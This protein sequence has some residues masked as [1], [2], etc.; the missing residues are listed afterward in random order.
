MPLFNL[1]KTAGAPTQPKSTT[2]TQQQAKAGLLVTAELD[3]ALEDC[4]ARV[5]DIAK[6]CR[7]KNRKFR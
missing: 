5:A 7:A 3:K 6:E 2:Y 4:K 1:F